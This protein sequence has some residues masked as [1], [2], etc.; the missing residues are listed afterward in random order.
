MK[1][2]G[3]S[4]PSGRGGTGVDC[5]GTRPGC[6]SI[7][8]NHGHSRHSLVSMAEGRG[9]DGRKSPDIS[10]KLGSQES[11]SQE[12][13]PGPPVNIRVG[14]AGA[15]LVK[16]RVTTDG[17]S[18]GQIMTTVIKTSRGVMYSECDGSGGGYWGFN[19]FYEFT[20]KRVTPGM[21]D[22]VDTSGYDS[23]PG[24]RGWRFVMKTVMVYCYTPAMIDWV[25][26][27]DPPLGFNSQLPPNEPYGDDIKATEP[28]PRSGRHYDDGRPPEF[29][30]RY[31]PA[32]TWTWFYD[33]NWDDCDGGGPTYIYRSP[34]QEDPEPEGGGT[35][36]GLPQSNGSA[37]TTT[38]PGEQPA[39]GSPLSTGETA[40][41]ARREATGL[42][43]SIRTEERFSDAA[44]R[45]HSWYGHAH[46]TSIPSLR[47]AAGLSSAP[48]S[49]RLPGWPS[50][51]LQR[52]SI[53]MTPLAWGGPAA[54]TQ[55]DG[56]ACTDSDV[57]RRG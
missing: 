33:A 24:T 46:W 8:Q 43:E 3:T 27:S 36:Y 17:C 44:N 47:H 34:V 54:L 20:T 28:G 31:E 40:P 9:K 2:P 52:A 32:Y 16:W 23:I 11:L 41:R 30:E 53:L 38:P 10:C 21:R 50:H 49:R 5:C 29:V 25:R 57:H 1:I 37:T 48:T 14:R 26:R 56:L 42:V 15:A 18:P 22:G 6:S 45:H 19:D 4:I 35:F 51:T 55:L 39:A 13:D 12:A 7:T